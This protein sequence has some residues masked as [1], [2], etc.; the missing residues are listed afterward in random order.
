MS[1]YRFW[2][3]GLEMH[4]YGDKSEEVDIDRRDD[5]SHCNR[6]TVNPRHPGSAELVAESRATLSEL[7]G[8]GLPGDSYPNLG[9]IR[10]ERN[11]VLLRQSGDRRIRNRVERF[12]GRRDLCALPRR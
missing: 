6:P 10:I 9:F 12:H 1:S 3:I 5:L 4:L 2:S 11:Q 8:S 7:L